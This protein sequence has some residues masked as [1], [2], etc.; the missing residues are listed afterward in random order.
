MLRRRDTPLKRTQKPVAKSPE[1]VAS[2]WIAQNPDVRLVLEIA[3]R[4]RMT[5]SFDLAISL[6]MA[7]EFALNPTISQL[8]AQ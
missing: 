1:S 8:P 7:Q 4:A 2:D 5:T 3:E 6:D